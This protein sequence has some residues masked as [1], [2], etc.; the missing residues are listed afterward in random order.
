MTQS[1]ISPRDRDCQFAF[2]PERRFAFRQPQ[3]HPQQFSENSITA[4]ARIAAPEHE[5]Q[6]G[7]DPQSLQLF[8]TAFYNNFIQRPLRG[9]GNFFI[10]TKTIF[11][12][13][14][15]VIEEKY[16]IS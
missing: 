3:W 12:A 6:R 11:F 15:T 4:E 1:V 14:N 2:Y 8:V 10:V 5:Q 16:L 7:L 9:L 13:P